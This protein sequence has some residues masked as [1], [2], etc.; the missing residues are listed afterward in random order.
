MKKTITTITKVI[1]KTSKKGLEY[2]QIITTNGVFL[3]FPCGYEPPRVGER[4]K[5]LAN[6]QVIAAITAPEVT[7]PLE[8]YCED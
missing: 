7:I 2:Q 1:Q 3:L 4:V 8:L 5:L 6:K